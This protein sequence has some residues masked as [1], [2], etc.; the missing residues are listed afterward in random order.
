MGH[1]SVLTRNSSLGS[2]LQIQERAQ[3]WNRTRVLSNFQIITTEQ[4]QR[5]GEHKDAKVLENKKNTGVKCFF[6]TRKTNTIK[7]IKHTFSLSSSL[8]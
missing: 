6:P 5:R 3:E 8:I 1:V 4:L 2:A 7:V